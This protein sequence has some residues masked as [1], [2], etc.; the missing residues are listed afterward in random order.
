ML[1]MATQVQSLQRIFYDRDN[2]YNG[3]DFEVTCSYLEV[4]NEL[5]YDLLVK[6]SGALE[7]REDPELGVQVRPL[8]SSHSLSDCVRT[9]EL[10][11]SSA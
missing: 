2:L 9:R 4:Y 5:I 6:A 1:A 10:H 3:M 8:A 7:L 11:Q